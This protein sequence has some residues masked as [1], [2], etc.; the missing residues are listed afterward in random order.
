MNDRG[1]TEALSLESTKE[2]R[3]NSPHKVPYMFKGPKYLNIRYLGLP[4]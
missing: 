1:P 3:S 2:Q 4:Y